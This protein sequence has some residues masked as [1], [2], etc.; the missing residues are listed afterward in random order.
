MKAPYSDSQTGRRAAA[1]QAGPAP[2]P[3]AQPVE[4]LVMDGLPPALGLPPLSAGASGSGPSRTPGLLGSRS[5]RRPLRS[6]KGCPSK[7]AGAARRA[8]GRGSLR[9]QPPR[10]YHPPRL[11]QNR[12][13]HPST[14]HPGG[15]PSEVLFGTLSVS[16]NPKMVLPPS[17]HVTIFWRESRTNSKPTTPRKARRLVV[18]T[19]CCLTGKSSKGDQIR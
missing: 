14:C 18:L 4:Q 13:R 5:Q 15:A 7:L 6:T 16:T 12:F 1:V 17:Y 11:L 3:V 19:T 2:T 9:H 8:G 10:P